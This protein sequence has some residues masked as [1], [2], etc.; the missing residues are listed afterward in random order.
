MR[1]SRD[2]QTTLIFAFSMGR[3][4]AKLGKVPLHG[5][6]RL[7][8]HFIYGFYPSHLLEKGLKYT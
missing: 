3:L 4:G 2:Y 5:K 6:A 1:C 8:T 7:L